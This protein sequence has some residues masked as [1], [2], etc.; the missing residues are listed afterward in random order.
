LLAVGDD[1]RPVVDRPLG[2]RREVLGPCRRARERGQQGQPGE[3]PAHRERG[4][5]A[6]AAGPSPSALSFAAGAA[7]AA[8]TPML[9]RLTVGAVCAADVASNGT[10]GLA[11]WMIR[12]PM[13][14][15]NVRIVVL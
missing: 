6:A 9:S 13:I 10:I 12:A 7:G 1:V 2:T 4:Q 11:P 14:S 8:G 5:L 3:D 15:G